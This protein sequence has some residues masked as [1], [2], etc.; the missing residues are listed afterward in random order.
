MINFRIYHQL[1]SAMPFITV[2]V[3]DPQGK[4]MFFLRIHPPQYTT[5]LYFICFT[6]NPKKT[7]ADSMEWKAQRKELLIMRGK[8]G[9]GV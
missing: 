8:Y 4:Y 7:D 5:L 2:T 1:G 3:F 9:G 6:S